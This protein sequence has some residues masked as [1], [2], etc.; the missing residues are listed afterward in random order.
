MD[1]NKPTEVTVSNKIKI[2]D[3]IAFK[4]IATGDCSA[5]TPAQKIEYYLAKCDAFSL[6][7]RTVPF[8][9]IKTKDKDG[10]VKETLYTKAVGAQS[11]AMIHKLSTEMR[12]EKEDGDTYVVWVRTSSPDG[13]FV[14]EI[15]ATPLTY[16][17]Y[18]KDSRKSETRP[19]TGTAR[20]DAR[21]KA[22][23]KAHRR[24]VNK[25]VGAGLDE[26]ELESLDI[27]SVTSVDPTASSLVVDKKQESPIPE[28]PIKESDAKK[29]GTAEG[30]ISPKQIAM[31]YA[32]IRVA[33]LN[34][35]DL[36]TQV[37]KMGYK[38]VREVPMAKVDV[39]LT[40]I[41]IAGKPTKDDSE[42]GMM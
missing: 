3:E 21:M 1:I 30:L 35:A 27:I 11:L 12:S 9:F 42:E 18:D 16:V 19:L 5:L 36:V 15:G 32:R 20:A 25:W 41:K 23:T 26:S 17:F 37:S 33:G 28:S 31:I 34:E 40:W 24:S 10:V 14:D 22:Y 2:S 13:R 8:E 39:L 7:P 4:L 6:D 38:S 29:L